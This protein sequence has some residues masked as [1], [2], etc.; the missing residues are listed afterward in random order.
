MGAK[1]LNY[2]RHECG[3]SES[4]GVRSVQPRQSEYIRGTGNNNTVRGEE[5][6]E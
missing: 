2:Y 3:F 5:K 1:D 4:L 6:S